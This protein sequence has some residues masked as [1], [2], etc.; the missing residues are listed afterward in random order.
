MRQTLN[1]H[2]YSC[3]IL[4]ALFPAGPPKWWSTM[5][6]NTPAWALVLPPHDRNFQLA[7]LLKG[8]HLL[9]FVLEILGPGLQ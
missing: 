5:C 3:Q 8:N 2:D 6:H 9:Q 1:Q 4:K 7:V